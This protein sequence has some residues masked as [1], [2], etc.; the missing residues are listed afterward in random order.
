MSDEAKCSCQRCGEYIEF[1]L[2]MAGQDAACPHCGR[3]TT[4]IVPK[5]GVRKATPSYTPP[6]PPS[7]ER[8][9]ESS[10]IVCSY[11]LCFLIPIV[12]FFCGIYL[13][14]KKQSGHGVVCM[15][16]SI[17]FGLVWLALIS[18]MG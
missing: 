15:A 8:P 4:L 5:S 3:E 7:A 6:L 10:T 12:G 2:A 16:I 13:M 14:T 11:V 18:E 17:V 1:P 9:L